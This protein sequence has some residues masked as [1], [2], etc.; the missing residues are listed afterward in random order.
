MKAVLVLIILVFHAVSMACWPYGNKTGSSISVAHVVS[1][2]HQKMEEFGYIPSEDTITKEDLETGMV[3][4]TKILLKELS[5]GTLKS[6]KHQTRIKALDDMIGENVFY[7][8]HDCC[9]EC[10]F[11]VLEKLAVSG[12]YASMESALKRQTS[13]MTVLM[14][15][16]HKDFMNEN[17]LDSTFG[18]VFDAASIG[19]KMSIVNSL[20][21]MYESEAEADKKYHTKAGMYLLWI[22]KRVGRCSYEIPPIKEEN[23][24][25]NVSLFLSRT[26]E[27]G[28]CRVGNPKEFLG[29]MSFRNG[30]LDTPVYMRFLSTEARNA[31]LGFMASN[32]KNI[33]LEE[34]K[35]KPKIITDLLEM[36]FINNTALA[37]VLSESTDEWTS[38]IGNCIHSISTARCMTDAITFIYELKRL[39]PH[40]MN[41]FFPQYA[42]GY[43]FPSFRDDNR[44]FKDNEF[45]RRLEFNQH[46]HVFVSGNI[47]AGVYNAQS[48][49]GGREIPDYLM[50]FDMQT[51]KMVWA[52]DLS[53]PMKIHKNDETKI[54]TYAT[55]MTWGFPTLGPRE[56]RLRGIG[57]NKISIYIMGNPIVYFVDTQT[58]SIHTMANISGPP[59]TSEEYD[60]LH[61]SDDLEFYYTVTDVGRDRIVTVGCKQHKEMDEES[62]LCYDFKTTE[63]NFGGHIV[64][65]GTHIGIIDEIADESVIITNPT[66]KNFTIKN[67]I[68]I[69]YHRGKIYT[70]ELDGNQ[71]NTYFLVVRTADVGEA[72]VSTV[73]KQIEI[74]STE[75][76]HFISMTA[77]SSKWFL[78]TYT[79][80]VVVEMDTERVLYG[81]TKIHN[82]AEIMVD[83]KAGTL[84]TWDQVSKEVKKF[85]GDFLSPAIVGTLNSGRGTSLLHVDEEEHLYF[86]D[87]PY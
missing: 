11:A 50:A 62:I 57:E 34:W 55:P 42:F 77:D 16:E 28:T 13:M 20:K 41:P 48:T 39:M 15:E 45:A 52:V 7:F 75:R 37:K 53:D 54:D 33:P 38:K 85:S 68:G 18:G 5:N 59:L 72:I 29:V 51:E 76:L 12:V 86:V 63:L 9:L 58:G 35:R 70:I 69:A 19:A 27:S 3:M 22:I 82:C 14:L 61:F 44:I 84:W 6:K 2:V 31:F 67:C 17:K 79:S 66:L 78:R 21:F 47:M 46:R 1:M 24:E 60:L 81:T 30:R 10:P 65:L 87:I 40:E 80:F 83:K 74:K 8:W 23:D 64:A 49:F 43:P 26:L 56:Y 73:E 71:D 25:F 36:S 32:L 4:F